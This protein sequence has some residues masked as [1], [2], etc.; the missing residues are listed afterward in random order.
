MTVRE[1]ARE[2]DVSLWRVWQLCVVGVIP[3]L[4]SEGLILIRPEDL[5]AYALAFPA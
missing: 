1:A 2:L 4:R 5:E 3:S